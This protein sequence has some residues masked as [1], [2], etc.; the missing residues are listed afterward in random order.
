MQDV[1]FG[2][3]NYSEEYGYTVHKN[4]LF[5]GKEQSKHKRL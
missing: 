1:T 4:V 3:V 5:G 2:E